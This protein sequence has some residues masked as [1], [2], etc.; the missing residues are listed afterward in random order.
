M[1]P[2]IG[3]LLVRNLKVMILTLGAS[4]RK[5]E[6]WTDIGNILREGSAKCTD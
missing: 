6:K 2:D 1:P 3:E 5:G 4:S